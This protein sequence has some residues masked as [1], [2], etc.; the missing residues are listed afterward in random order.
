MQKLVIANRGSKE[1]GKSSSLREVFGILSVKY[2]VNTIIDYGDIMATIQIGD[3]LIGLESQGD[4]SS[5]IFDSLRHFVE[6][7]CDV[8]ICACRTYGDTT[9]AVKALAYDGYQV[10]FTQNDKSDDESMQVVLNKRYAAR[11]VEMIEER[12]K[13][14]F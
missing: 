8:I 4:P 10:I 14:V 6:L 3:F 1:Q 9:D 2:P 5:R 12:I 13:G 7:G 11:I